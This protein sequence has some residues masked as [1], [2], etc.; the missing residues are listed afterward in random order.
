MKIKLLT[1]IMLCLLSSTA[2]ADDD[3]HKFRVGF[4]VDISVPAGAAVGVVIHPMIDW[5]SVETSLTYNA[6]NFG[7]RASL[8]IDPLALLPRLPI[9]VFADV[10]GGF[11]AN[12]NV[13]FEHNL[14][15]VGYDYV[16][17]YGGL[18]FG[19]MNNFHWLVEVGPTYI[20]ANTNNFQSAV[21]KVGNGISFSDPKVSGWVAPTFLTGFEVV[22]R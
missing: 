20:F 22:F 8:K 10:Q 4:G 12:G 9:G 11:A 19:R 7:G 17:L 1:T 15:S 16:N 13:P 21:G 5:V 18:R 14:P 3:P 2:Y 6:L